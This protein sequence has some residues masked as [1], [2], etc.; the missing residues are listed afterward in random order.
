[1]NKEEL[2]KECELLRET[3]KYLRHRRYVYELALV[4]IAEA[5][6]GSDMKTYQDIADAALRGETQQEKP[7]KPAKDHPWRKSNRRTM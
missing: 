3:V 7:Y 4:R 6:E 5:K 2:L 1:M